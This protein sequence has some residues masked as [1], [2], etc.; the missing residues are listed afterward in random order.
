VFVSW[1]RCLT[2]KLG[3]RVAYGWFG[4]VVCVDV[5]LW[6]A[7]CARGAQLRC[8]RTQSVVRS[9]ETDFLAGNHGV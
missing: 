2:R 1:S 6:S 5:C 8:R 3:F 4:H 7:V 9:L